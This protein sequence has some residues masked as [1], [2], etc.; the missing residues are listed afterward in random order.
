M[1]PIRRL[2]PYIHLYDTGAG[3]L[4]FTLAPNRNIVLIAI[5]LHLSGN[6]QGNEKFTATVDSTEGSAH[7]VVAASQNMTGNADFV[8]LYEADGLPF[9]RGDEIDFAFANSGSVTFGL[10]VVYRE[11]A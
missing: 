8:R 1:P 7:D 3:V 5:K 2:S 9:E 6:G 4:A 10:E 11:E